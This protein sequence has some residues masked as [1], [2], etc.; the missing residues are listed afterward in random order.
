MSYLNLVFILVF[1]NTISGFTPVSRT[2]ISTKNGDYSLTSLNSLR[3][4]KLNSLNM[5][6][7]LPIPPQSIVKESITT[8]TKSLTK[9][10]KTS[11][12]SLQDKIS[13]SLSLSYKALLALTAAF[14]ARFRKQ[15]NQT[16]N[17]MEDG[18]SKR[19]YGNAFSRTIEVWGF[20]ITYLIKFFSLRKKEKTLSKDE[21]AKEQTKL[22]II[23]RE[24]LLELGPTFIKLGQLLSTRIDILPKPF[25][26]ELVLLQDQV[27]G[28]S[29][30]IAKSIIESELGKP[31]DVLYDKGSFNDQPLA[32]A[33]LGQVHTATLNGRKVA[34][35]VQRQG[36]KALFDV[37]LKNIK[38]LA[39]ILDKIDPKSDGAARDWVSIYEES[40]RLLYREI[41]Y[42]L[43]AENAL[44]FQTNFQNV[45]WVKV[46]D[47]YFNLTTPTMITMEYVKGIKTNDIEAIEKA[48]IDRE[49]L[50]RKSA[51]SYLTQLCRH[52]FFHCDPHPGNVA[53]DAANGGRLIY[54]DFGMMDELKPDVKRGLVN[55]IFGVYESDAKEVCD[56]L[57]EMEVLK[58]GVDRISV[59]KIARYFLNE[60]K[61]GSSN[62]GTYT[63]DLPKEE[64]KKLRRRRRAQ[65]GEDLFSVGSDV[66]F[67]FPPTFTF[68]FRAFTSL[69]GIGK[70]LDPAYDLTKIAQPFLKELIDLRDGSAFLSLV[71]TW[72]KKLGW[73]PIDINN[74]ISSPRKVAYLEDT[75]SKMEQGDLKLRVRVLDS[76]RQFNRM[77]LVQD[78]IAN[79][80]AASAFLN[81]GVVLASN[82]NP[83]TKLVSQATKGA[84]LLAGVFGIQVP[85]GLFKLKS[86]DKKFASFD[87]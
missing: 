5:K 20:T 39:Q 13:N 76:E 7:A 10:T 51:E 29:G 58:R 17:A 43:E 77:N 32:A 72:G 66:P 74:A 1:V 42:E 55:L 64:A 67:R 2:I 49:D 61:D 28:F 50:A 52:G 82:T 18:W 83:T 44:R 37:D 81:I 6:V 35:K 31:I 59:E 19:G 34:I 54:Y 45:P 21:Y 14:I 25:I 57:E 65:L 53:C 60:F 47:V 70:G 30:D 24:K 63:K 80:L 4:N 9:L 86:L 33:S 78:N 85:I 68:V 69:D 15:I 71:K 79:A 3:Y 12:F 40:A 38:V 22:A 75:I 46:P 11:L 23:L 48:G 84:L 41:N 56:S 73:R 16:Y 8:T 26:D 62:D 27:P 36:L 87:S